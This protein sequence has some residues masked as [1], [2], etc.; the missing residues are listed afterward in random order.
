MVSRYSCMGSETCVFTAATK[1]SGYLILT[2]AHQ[3]LEAPQLRPEVRVH[4]GGLAVGHEAAA[5]QHRQGRVV[6]G[7][8]QRLDRSEGDP[9]ELQCHSFFSYEAFSVGSYI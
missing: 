7:L 4:A 1:T 9:P 5:P 2:A 8:D 6:A 3:P